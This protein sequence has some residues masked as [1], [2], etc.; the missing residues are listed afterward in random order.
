MR[1]S[2]TFSWPRTGTTCALVSLTGAFEDRRGLR[3][4]VAGGG[5]CMARLQ[6]G[7]DPFRVGVEAPGGEDVCFEWVIYHDHLD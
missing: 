4:A 7:C 1:S 2:D 6:V 5:G 3:R